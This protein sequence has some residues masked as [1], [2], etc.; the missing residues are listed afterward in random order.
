MTGQVDA[1]TARQLADLVSGVVSGDLDRVIAAVA[2]I[3]DIGEDK[4]DD[5][6]LRADVHAIVS[7]FQGTPL[8][9]LNLG[10]VLQN[11]FA[12]LRATRSGVPPTSS[13]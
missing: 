9:R 4:L 1:R 7:E 13:C 12:A 6:G 10:G 8:D 2:A 11:F 3:A 5:R